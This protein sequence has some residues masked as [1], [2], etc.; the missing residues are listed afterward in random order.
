MTK[1]LLEGRFQVPAKSFFSTGVAWPGD[2]DG[3]E[4]RERTSKVSKLNQIL[5]I[6]PNSIILL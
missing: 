2:W 3:G 5:T 4:Q 1:D 6:I